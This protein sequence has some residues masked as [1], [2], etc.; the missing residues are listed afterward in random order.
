MRI[1]KYFR[2][3]GFKFS[4]LRNRATLLRICNLPPDGTAMLTTDEEKLLT[5]L[6]KRLRPS[7]VATRNGKA[8]Y[9]LKSIEEIGLWAILEARRATNAI[10]RISAWSDDNYEPQTVLD[11]AKLDKYI[12]EQLEYADNLERVIFQNMRNTGESALTGDENIKQAKNLLGLVQ[13][14]AELFHCSFEDAKKMNYSDAML[15]I[16]KRND[17]IEKEKKELKKQQQKYR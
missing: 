17:E 3:L 2:N 10:G 7:Q 14:T 8:V 15:A 5:N 16:A 4:M 9:R 12:V 1:K 6:I 11:A 13:V